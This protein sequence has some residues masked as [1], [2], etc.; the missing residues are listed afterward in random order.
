M[1]LA[2]F[3]LDSLARDR[4]G[5]LARLR[6]NSLSRVMR[7]ISARSRLRFYHIQ[8]IIRERAWT[9]MALARTY[10]TQGI[11]T[12]I[13]IRAMRKQR[14]TVEAR[15]PTA[16]VVIAVDMHAV[17]GRRTRSSRRR[18]GVALD[19]GRQ[20]I[21]APVDGG[22]DVRGHSHA[23]D[24]CLDCVEFGIAGRGFSPGEDGHD[25]AED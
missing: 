5:S 21:G 3:R 8:A 19:G 9:M 1:R 6:R 2:P 11:H 13:A 7:N 10:P 18:D 12:M 17:A 16:H 23:P 22:E 15:R 24:V 20:G 4:D 25:E 14:A